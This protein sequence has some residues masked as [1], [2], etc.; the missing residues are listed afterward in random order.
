[1]DENFAAWMIAGGTRAQDPHDARDR[2][3]L[4]AFREGRREARAQRPGLIARV[5]G[6][7]QPNAARPD[8]TCCPA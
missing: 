6:I 1:M 4:R 8:P 3:Q 7:I 5:R 2:A